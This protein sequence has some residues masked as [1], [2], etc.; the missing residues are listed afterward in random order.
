M[1]QHLSLNLDRFFPD[2]FSPKNGYLISPT[3]DIQPPFWL[4]RHPVVF[5][6]HMG[7]Y[8]PAKHSTLKETTEKSEVFFFVKQ[9]QT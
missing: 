7:F 8:R 5:C 2:I 4:G 6:Q 9:K 3:K 1:N